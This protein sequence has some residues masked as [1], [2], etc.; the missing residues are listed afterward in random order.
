M[1][2]FSIL[3]LDD[4]DIVYL[5]ILSFRNLIG[6]SYCSM[7]HLL[8]EIKLFPKLFQIFSNYYNTEHEKILQQIIL[9]I[10]NCCERATFNEIEE[11][12][13]ESLFNE[14]LNFL[15]ENNYSM[16]YYY[17]KFI[18][19]ILEKEE[20]F[21]IEKTINKNDESDYTIFY[22]KY[23]KNSYKSCFIQSNGKEKLNKVKDIYKNNILNEEIDKIF[24]LLI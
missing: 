10:Y 24:K 20:E 21:N 17:I 3:D 19:I 2:L 7:V 14:F 6:N 15:D 5:T 4:A 12:I 13:S 16:I 9:L 22:Y 1:T 23:S 8:F 11:I 18:E